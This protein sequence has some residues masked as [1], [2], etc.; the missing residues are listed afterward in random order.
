MTALHFIEFCR[1]VDSHAGL[2]GISLPATLALDYPSIDALSAYI[3]DRARP[4]V[5]LRSAKALRKRS[6]PSER[7]WAA[8]VTAAA[9]RVGEPPGY[10]EA[11]SHMPQLSGVDAVKTVP[12]DRWG[13]DGYEHMSD[14]VT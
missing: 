10:Q 5:T 9:V 12:I 8:L 7:S 1:C 13:V 14:Q 2:F 11:S 4:A 6:K 3:A